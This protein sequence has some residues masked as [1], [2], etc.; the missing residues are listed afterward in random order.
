MDGSF[1]MSK[2]GSISAKQPLL[3]KEPCDCQESPPAVIP[4]RI[5]NFKYPVS[6]GKE[7]IIGS[8]TTAAELCSERQMSNLFDFSTYWFTVFELQKCA[9]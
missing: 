7:K 2:T 8:R 5:G 9:Y 3:R 1:L 4:K 6:R